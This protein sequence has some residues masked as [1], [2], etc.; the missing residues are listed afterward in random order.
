MQKTKVSRRSIGARQSPE[1]AAAILDAAADLLRREGIRGLT[2]DAIARE[3]RA[4][5]TT[6]Y[7]WWPTRGA[8]LL[9]IYLRIKGEYARPDTGSVIDD[10]AQTLNQV[11]TAWCNEGRIFALIIA[12]AQHEET[13]A[14]SLKAFRQERIAGWESVLQRALARGELIADANLSAIAQSILA[15][16][17]LYL[18][19]D[20]LDR[21][22]FKLASDVV[23]PWI[24]S[25]PV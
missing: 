18:L 1:A 16:A 9:A 5:K 22:T 7:K 11:F 13:V 2:Y 19:T 15:H 8:L 21:D 6:L 14:E 23:G 25:K 17:W 20:Q 4:S 10:V 24:R 12:E 3:A